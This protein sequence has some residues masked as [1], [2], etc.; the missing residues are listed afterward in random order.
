MAF[1]EEA[2][3]EIFLLNA[4]TGQIENK[5]LKIIPKQMTEESSER[6]KSST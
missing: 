1:F 2:S 5:S 4:E 6:G 3:N